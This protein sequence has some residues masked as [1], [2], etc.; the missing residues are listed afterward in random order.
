LGFIVPDI[1]NK[2]FRLASVV[3]VVFPVL[4]VSITVPVMIP[5]TA[6]IFANY[7]PRRDEQTE[8]GQQDE[9]F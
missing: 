9:D 2:E 4:F 8:H 5:V 3:V 6:A 7:A 1:L